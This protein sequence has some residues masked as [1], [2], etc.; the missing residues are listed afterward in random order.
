M[1]GSSSLL[2]TVFTVESWITDGTVLGTIL[3]KDI[4]PGINSSDSASAGYDFTALGKVIFRVNDQ[5]N[6]GTEP[7]ITDGTSAG[8][9]LLKDIN[10]GVD[11][12]YPG[13]F[14][15]LGNGKAIFQTEDGSTSEAVVKV[16][17]QVGLA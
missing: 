16:K 4:I 9:K 12:S 15:A 7:W 2:L 17:T 10:Q 6:I 11:G 8:T 14:T 13:N 3:L 1:A 5:Y